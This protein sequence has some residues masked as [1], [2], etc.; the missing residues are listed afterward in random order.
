MHRLVFQ[1]TSGGFRAHATL[2]DNHFNAGFF[3]E[4]PFEFFHA[5]ACGWSDRN[6]LEAAVI[7]LTNNRPSVKNGPAPQ[8]NRQLAL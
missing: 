5:H 6:H 2:A 8:I 3:D 7:F 1:A 4:L